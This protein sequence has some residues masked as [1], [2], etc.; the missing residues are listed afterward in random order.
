VR[1][2]VRLQL[3]G[4]SRSV[5][6]REAVEVPIGSTLDA[7]RGTVSVVTTKRRGG[8]AV[9]EGRF[10]GGAFTVLQR[11]VARPVTQLR[12]TGGRFRACRRSGVGRASVRV[13]LRARLATKQRGK[14]QVRGRYSVGGSYGTTWLTEDRCDGTL[15]RVLSGA[16]R[17][18]DLRRH[19][20][21]VVRAGHRY[22]ARA[23]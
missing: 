19:R 14:T 3:P 16:V 9:Q 5:P 15:T 6:L 21:V 22:L 20:T 8:G 11:R 12:L 2:T 10:R 23:R 17:V 7:R 13:R 18:R 4:A 1:G